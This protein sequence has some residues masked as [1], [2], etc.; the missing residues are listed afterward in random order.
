MNAVMIKPVDI[1]MK[2]EVKL[3]LAEEMSLVS[4]FRLEQLKCSFCNSVVVGTTLSA[5]GSSDT[6]GRQGFRDELVIKLSAALR[7]KHLNTV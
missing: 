2:F 6:K 4:E 3:L 5:K 1:I 7:M